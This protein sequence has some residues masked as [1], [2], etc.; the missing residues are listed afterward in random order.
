[1]ATTLKTLQ[2]SGLGYT[3]LTLG[4]KTDSGSVTGGYGGGGQPQGGDSGAAFLGDDDT[5][6]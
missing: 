4:E 6:F 3:C 2:G 5:P 1:M